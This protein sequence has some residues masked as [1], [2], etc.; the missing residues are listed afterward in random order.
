MAKVYQVN[1]LKSLPVA[2]LSSIGNFKLSSL[3]DVDFTNYWEKCS[4]LLTPYSIDYKRRC[5]VFVETS[6]SAAQL[7]SAP[8]LYQ[9][10]RDL[11]QRVFLLSF[12]EVLALDPKTIDHEKNLVFLHS[13]GRCG[14]TLL[15]K[16]LEDTGEV[17]AISEPDYYTQ[18]AMLDQQYGSSLDRRMPAVIEK[19]T[20]LLL[21]E[22]EGDSKKD[23]VVKLRGVCIH[24]ADQLQQ[25]HPYTQNVFLY[26]N[27]HD[28]SNSF[29]GL[30]NKL[31]P[32]RAAKSFS[33]DKLPVYWLGKL[34]IVRDKVVLFAPLIL[35]A[36]YKGVAGVG[37]VL[38]L[39]WLSK[40]N[41]ALCLMQDYPHFFACAVR[42]EDLL[43]DPSRLVRALVPLIGG[44]RPDHFASL[45]MRKTMASNSQQGS[46]VESDGKYRLDKQDVD[47]IN[48]V[49]SR[50]EII[51]HAHY[52]LPNTLTTVG[53]IASDEALAASA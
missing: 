42:Y 37:A 43:Q 22:L 36:R 38:A 8:F 12:D 9:A 17:S 11:A 13:T 28:T 41:R 14:S 19:L 25:A 32:V 2:E 26:R 46:D 49:L 33:L 10:Q 47:V 51:N 24:I 40:M 3:A 15:C 31:G 34:P 20:S 7:K 52:V 4:K 45:K 16:L 53:N 39:S 18:W 5:A 1:G 27:A 23:V 50:H 29:L 6:G 35:D 44:H 21:A 48:R 30:L